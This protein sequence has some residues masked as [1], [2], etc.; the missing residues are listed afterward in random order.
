MPRRPI[1][2]AQ[3]IAPFG[4][5]AMVVAPDGTSMI[6]AGLDYW[7]PEGSSEQRVDL[8]E[9]ELGEW[10]LQRELQVDLFR[11]PPDYRRPEPW[12][13]RTN[14]NLKIPFLR[15]PQWHVCPRC[16]RLEWFPL[17]RIATPRCPACQAK[18]VGKKGK[19][20]RVPFMVQVRFIALCE[21]GH[22]QDFPW[23]E[24]AHRT[25][26]PTC[27]KPMRLLALGGA[28]LSATRV[29]CEC[30]ASRSLE[31]IT[32]ADP[33]AQG[34]QRSGGDGREPSSTLSRELAPDGAEYRC[35]GMRP[36]LG[37][38]TGEG[39]G[40][41]LRGSLRGATNVHYSVTRSAIYL[42]RGQDVVPDGLMEVLEMP[43]VSEFIAI[44]TG[45]GGTVTPTQIKRQY[46]ELVS[47]YS[48]E[49]IA[50]GIKVVTD[51]STAATSAAAMDRPADEDPETTFRRDEYAA[52]QLAQREDQLRTTPVPLSRY[53]DWIRPALA[54][55]T[56]VEKLRETRALTGFTRVYPDD[57]RSLDERKAMLWRSS[58]AP[59]GW[60]PAYVVHGEGIYLGLAEE[61]VREW[62][63]RE[64]VSQRLD[65]LNSRYRRVQA[66]R[67]L[68]Q[69]VVS[70]RFVL[71]HTLA[72][73]LMNQ[74]TF[75]CGYS[76]ASLRERLYVSPYVPAPMAGVLIYTAAGD[77][78]GTMG[79]LVRMGKPDYLEPIIR[80]ALDNARWCSADPVCME[81]GDA[82]GQ[83]PDSCNLA[84]CHNC[85]LVPETSC[86][87]FNRFLDRGLLVGTL[88]DQSLGFFSR[89]L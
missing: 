36:W 83:G 13:D 46:G 77:S 62:E 26:T 27:T 41:P 10:R 33:R 43:R 19:A 25:A 6:A 67:G 45:S 1:R 23:R 39:C 76:S 20:R 47:D 28:G 72:H 75:E 50:A 54:R 89:V 84:A 56:L 29:S 61:E 55:V 88:E 53:A 66:E 7:Y 85:A 24:W 63:G 18:E 15:F 42:P 2:R 34:T 82:G 70:P 9:F 57:G 32:Q 30:E 17:V 35:P 40:A 58:R 68:S 69:R 52:L 60:L 16:Q 51:T 11:L 48:D 5:G 74:L 38:N 14:T 8:T 86:E 4:P 22:I 81:V 79:G 12:R 87:Q 59:N 78:E 65:G 73:L 44:I 37:D 31:G 64:D 21:R 3:L 80:R 49:Q 71:L